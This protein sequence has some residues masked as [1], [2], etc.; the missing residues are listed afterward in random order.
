LIPSRSTKYNLTMVNRE[1]I[2]QNVKNGLWTLFNLFEDSPESYKVIFAFA[3]LVA[4]ESIAK[5]A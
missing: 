3:G 2:M 4:I 5:M 1:T